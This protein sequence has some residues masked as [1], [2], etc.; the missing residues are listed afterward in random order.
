MN[1][2]EILEMIEKAIAWGW[3]PLEGISY[4]NTTV[5]TDRFIDRIEIVFGYKDANN[6]VDIDKWS[7]YEVIF[8]PGFAKAVWGTEPRLVN[9]ETFPETFPMTIE[10]WKRHLQ[11]M[12]LAP[13]PLEYIK[14]KARNR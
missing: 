8:D 9:K 11:E 3:C 2:G 4:K 12:V 6:I 5:R 10:P 13:D 7:V 14:Y 1:S